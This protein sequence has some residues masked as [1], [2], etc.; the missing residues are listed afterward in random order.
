M[1][2][3]A[4][5]SIAMLSIAMPMLRAVWQPCKLLVSETTGT[6]SSTFDPAQI[7]ELAKH[8][9]APTNH[10][11]PPVRP[12]ALLPPVLRGELDGAVPVLH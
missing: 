8:A 2:S 7:R 5:P 11:T 6:L 12:V 3:I 4:M 9:R 1:P 10:V